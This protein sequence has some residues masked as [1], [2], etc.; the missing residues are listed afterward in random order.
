MRA[1]CAPLGMKTETPYTR[2]FTEN[3][4]EP[5]LH[6][7]PG[8]NMAAQGVCIFIRKRRAGERPPSNGSGE[9]FGRLQI[10]C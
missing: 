1:F 3:I 2:I 9:P 4:H 7:S 5:F 8:M 6:F 10:V